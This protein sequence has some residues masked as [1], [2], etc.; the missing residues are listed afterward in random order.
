MKTSKKITVP[1][2]SQQKKIWYK[3]RNQAEWIGLIQQC[4][5]YFEHT[6]VAI[7]ALFYYETLFNVDNPKLYFSLAMAMYM[8]A[9]MTSVTVCGH[10]MDR[11]RNVRRIA[12][13]TLAI[14]VIGNLVYTMTYSKWFPILGR[15][16][17][18]INNGSRTSLAGK[19][20][21][22]ILNILS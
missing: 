18:G 11:T 13:V 4:L 10:Y 7:S 9:A 17:C 21:L 16:L 19:T 6:A 8:T 5:L 14:L 3:R 15:F 12:L 1:D 2:I 22:Q 20:P